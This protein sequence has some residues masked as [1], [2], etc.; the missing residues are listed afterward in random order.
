MKREYSNPSALPDWS[1]MFTQIVTTEKQGLRLVHISGQVGVDQDKKIVGDGSLA[2]QTQQALENLKVA[3]SHVGVSVNDVV[4]LTI[5]VADYQ[6]EH[7]AVIREALR[8]VFP[9][10][11]LP[12]LSLIGIAALAEK[13]FLVEI[14]AE[15][16]AETDQ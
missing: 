3:L 1:G 11:Q 8:V 14:D 4:K 9:S 10:D 7:A 2:A 12:A 15:I 6:Y 5:Y 13:E 16:V